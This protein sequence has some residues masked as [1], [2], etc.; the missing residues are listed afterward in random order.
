MSSHAPHAIEIDVDE[1]DVDDLALVASCSSSVASEVPVA[2]S[3]T[4]RN[5]F[6][7]TVAPVTTTTSTSTS[8][9]SSASTRHTSVGFRNSNS[10]N[11]QPQDSRQ[12]TKATMALLSP[13][14]SVNQGLNRQSLSGTQSNND[15]NL[16][17]PEAP[18]ATSSPLHMA[19]GFTAYDAY[20]VSSQ[21]PTHYHLDAQ[22]NQEDQAHLPLPTAT[23]ATG[24]SA[25]PSSSTLNNPTSSAGNPQVMMNAAVTVV[26]DSTNTTNSANNH[27]NANNKVVQAQQAG[28]ADYLENRNLQASLGGIL[29]L[30]V[31]GAAVIVA[32]V[33]VFSMSSSNSDPVTM[34]PTTS[35]TPTTTTVP[36]FMTLLPT[37]APTHLDV[38]S[39]PPQQPFSTTS[40]PSSSQSIVPAPTPIPLLA[41][42]PDFT[43]ATIQR[44][45]NS[46]QALAFKWLQE[47]PDIA[48]MPVWERQQYIAI[49][50][51]FYAT[52]GT[53]SWSDE[54][55]YK[56][57]V[58]KYDKPV[59][60]WLPTERMPSNGQI[61]P[62]N[63]EGKLTH[64]RL[65]N[66][67][68]DRIGTPQDGTGSHLHG[69]M[70]P[71]ISLLTDVQTIQIY[72]CRLDK[73]T[74]QAF[75][76]TELSLLP[77][78]ERLVF[79]QSQLNGPI[80]AHASS[81]LTALTHLNLDWN[82]L[83]GSIPS[84]IGFMTS[85]RFL[86]LAYNNVAGHVPSEIGNL[87]HLTTLRLD[88]N[89]LS[90][91]LPATELLQLTN[92]REFTIERNELRGRNLPNEFCELLPSLETF[93]LDCREVACPAS[94]PCSCA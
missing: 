63:G 51:I 87:S 31:C 42:L 46:P 43:V 16:Q 79:F 15:P 82:N 69:T 57:N 14:R 3:G 52:N 7:K 21:E 84:E 86:S 45:P 19:E 54:S 29:G 48:S 76:P 8:T 11:R 55:T 74:L 12:P 56:R 4:S 13:P 22:S 91:T 53:A 89:E 38:S 10:S 93:R 60:T 85:L 71:E 47:H 83:M 39:L 36:S 90:G 23:A 25:I 62:C 26:M 33:V 88:H 70:P 28:L 41:D 30:V 40:V 77:K 61:Y 92:L 78:L 81:P 49:G 72:N 50:S 17:D 9:S 80:P 68:G 35:L 20:E 6:K 73:F 66:I 44:E 34:A 2:T 94:C 65:E 59:C 64:L 32:L 18:M 58:L 24:S 27:D 67:Q 5:A 37:L 1:I 75:W